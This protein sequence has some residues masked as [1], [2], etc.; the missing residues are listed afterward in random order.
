MRESYCQ[1]PQLELLLKSEAHWHKCSQNSFSDIANTSVFAGR[2][3]A[4]LSHKLHRICI[5]SCAL[6]INGFGRAI[7]LHQI[8][9]SSTYLMLRA[10]RV[11][12]RA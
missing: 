7:R 6:V 10:L 2:N 1:Y 8:Q 11:L 4:L 3:H 5:A 12:G 9:V